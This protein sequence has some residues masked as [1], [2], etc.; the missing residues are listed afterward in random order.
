[1]N[2]IDAQDL[3]LIIKLK[4]LLKEKYGLLIASIYCYGSRVTKGNKE[5]D[6]D[7]LILTEKKLNWQ[8]Q[9]KIKNEVYDFGIENDLVFDP[10]IFSLYQFENQ[11]SYLPFV[12]SVKSTGI[13]I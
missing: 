10:K 8:D 2:K 7:I 5:S 3:N 1:M 12:Q 6:F 13:L 11:F 9:R 4:E